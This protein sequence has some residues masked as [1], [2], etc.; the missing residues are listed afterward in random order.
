MIKYTVQLCQLCQFLIVSH[1]ETLDETSLF[2]L[3]NALK[4]TYGKVEFKK[5]SGGVTPGPPL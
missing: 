1:N 3:K 4:L 2:C 5:F